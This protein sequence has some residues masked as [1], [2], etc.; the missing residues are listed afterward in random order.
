MPSDF[1]YA[2]RILSK[3][4][5]FTI[6]AV[7]TLALGIGANSAIF[8]VIRSVLLQPL[9]FKDS[10]RLVM[11]A[12]MLERG[13]N[14]R[15]PLSFPDFY[16]YRAQ[17][18]SF[19]GL[20]YY[21]PADTVLSGGAE[22]QAVSGIV[23]GGDFFE[24][25]GDPVLGRGFTA[26]EA[27]TGRPNVIV[28]SHGL[29]QRAFGGNP[30]IVGQQV[31]MTSRT[32]TVLGVMGQGWKFPVEAETTDFI[33]PWEPLVNNVTDR[34]AHDLACV[35]RLKQSVAI[36]QA[37]LELKAIAAALTR[38]YPETNKDRTI[39]LAPL[40]QE[41]VG[42][43]RPALLVLVGAVALV[44]LIACANV[45]NLLIARSAARKREFALRVALG[46]TRP[47][48]IRQLLTESFF[49]SL[50]GATFGLLLAWGSLNL[51]RSF[52][53]RS[54]PR[55][56]DV[57]IDLSV[58]AFAFGLAILTA[59]L[60]GLVPALRI[61]RPNLTEALQQGAKGSSGGFHRTSIRG[62]LVI[63]QVSLA[64]LLLSG[65]GLLL[66]S[67]FNL[68]ATD[69]GFDPSG[70]V[71]LYQFVP[72]TYSDAQKQRD[73]YGRLIPKLGA[74]PGVSSV[75]G[76]TPLPFS[77]FD[78]SVRFR[79]E[80]DPD[81]G[82]ATHPSAAY[83]SVT[84]NYFRTMRI[85]LRS[86]RVFED[87]DN[88]NAPN[89]ALINET[90]ASRFVITGNPIGQR[91]II[92][93]AAGEPEVIEIVGIIGDT[94]QNAVGAPA[95]AT[96]YQPFAQAPNRR[97]WLVFRMASQNLLGL[98]ANVRRI[99][100]EQDREIYVGNIQP[101]EASIGKTL[102][103]ARFNMAL[104]GVF[105]IVA[106]LLAAIGIY[107]VIAYT[108]AQ[109]TREIGIHM[110]LGAQR[111]DMFRMVL[112]QSLTL[113]AIGIVI[114]LLGAMAATRALASLLYG[115]SPNDLLTYVSVC[116]LLGSAAL[117]ASFIPASRAMKVDPIVALR[118]E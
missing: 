29:W 99:I 20:A 79:M 48:I 21:G 55:L 14:V 16:D 95:P 113:V 76:A 56:S 13:H 83:A 22:A 38:Q 101:M 51:L 109:R 9:P 112:R 118:S 26:D 72:R 107:G 1:R 24:T 81:R 49:L 6:V 36:K 87:R 18:H 94:K 31:M 78:W 93:R 64:L 98:Q 68:L 61:S 74:L 108:V 110:A 116:V 11:V 19:E 5:G 96:I 27:K 103:Q 33:M 97:L 77:E 40:L 85:P 45:A 84:P 35:G 91:I 54:V 47:E 23:V 44:L 43:V 69:L 7:L 42:N 66:R 37:E 70:L 105:A 59:L 53:P 89:V 8:S 104:L 15:S 4:P 39:T 88:E 3:S 46:A 63:S 114:G 86:G 90:F 12:N 67:F 62:A 10:D 92:D 17:S 50:V 115:V 58:T 117:L 75:G 25:L 111:S 2:G 80:N 41:I 57:H 28:I 34:G 52:G 102:A 30:G 73:F 106:T 100:Q 32:Y 71:V 60:F 65:A 82:P